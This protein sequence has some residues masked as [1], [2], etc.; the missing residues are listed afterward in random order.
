MA[1]YRQIH[2]RIWQDKNVEKLS[3]QGK[4][5]FMYSWSNSYRNEVCLY[6][7]TKRK[8]VYE[9]GIDPSQI[10]EVI[11]EVEDAGLIRYDHENDYIWAKNAIKYQSINSNNMTAMLR[12]IAECKSPL[13]LECAQY[14]REAL[15]SHIDKWG[16]AWTWDEHGMPIPLESH[17]G[18]G[19]GK[20]KGNSKKDIPPKPPVPKKIHYAEFV[21]MTEDE[22]K[23]LVD[24][25]GE[26]KTKEMIERLC[27]Y[28]GSTG[29][30]Y[31]SDYMTILAWDRKDKKEN[32]KPPVSPP[33]NKIHIDPK[34][35]A[36][37]TNP[38]RKAVPHGDTS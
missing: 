8:I 18:K 30:K 26:E 29:T 21:T 11:K 6:E 22:Y 23:K 15:Q 28:K 4:M 25:L 3:L 38:P 20:G 37:Y 5:L 2:V 24:E 32:P 9:T 10:D 1:T 14:H 12:D 33:P 27:L 7:L 17:T 34:L 31:K 16:M 19:K 35:L 36:K 13:A